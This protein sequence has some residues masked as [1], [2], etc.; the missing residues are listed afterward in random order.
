MSL[1]VNANENQTAM[2]CSA[3]SEISPGEAKLADDDIS[4]ALNW[5]RSI[6]AC[7]D[8]L[9]NFGS[10]AKFEFQ[11]GQAYIK[12]GQDDKGILRLVKAG[13]QGYVPAQN[14]LATA[15]YFGEGVSQSYKEALK[16]NLK[17]AKQGDY[18]SQFNVGYAYHVGEGVERDYVVAA[19]W[20]SMSAEQGYADAQFN[21]AQSYFYGEGVEQNYAQ[22]SRLYQKAAE[23]GDANAMTALGNAL[24]EGKGVNQDV[25]DGIMWLTKAANTGDIDAEIALFQRY[26]SDKNISDFA[27]SMAAEHIFSALKNSQDTMLNY[28]QK[29]RVK[30]LNYVMLDRGFGVNRNQKEAMKWLKDSAEDGFFLAQLDLAHRLA[31]GNGV[32]ENTKKAKELFSII[33]S[34]GH[35]VPM[36]FGVN[37]T[38]SSP[39]KLS[40]QCSELWSDNSSLA[41]SP[42][43]DSHIPI[44]LS[45]H[46][47]LIDLN[48]IDTKNQTVNASLKL[49]Y[50]F[51]DVR[52]LF[53]KAYFGTDICSAP[54]HVLWE[55]LP[56]KEPIS[57]SPKIGALNANNIINK[58]TD[59]IHLKSSGSVAYES[60][61]LGDF[62][63][64]LNLKNFPLDV[65]SVPLKF[66]SSTFSLSKVRLIPFENNKF[67]SALNRNED[68]QEWRIVDQKLSFS[69]E[70]RDGRLFSIATFNIDIKRSPQY[71]IYKVI[72][73][74]F[75]LFLVA[76]SQFWLRWDRLDARVSIATTSLVAVIAYQFLIQGDLPKLPYLTLLDKIVFLTF[77][78]IALSIAELVLVFS[79]IRQKRPNFDLSRLSPHLSL[80]ISPKVLAEKIDTHS[81]YAF[82]LFWLISSGILAFSPILSWINA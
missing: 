25:A 80:Q 53:N 24:L 74:L 30:Y 61:I 46:A 6:N 73:P 17:S 62:R 55:S 68:R 19:K 22:A 54:A 14:F 33:R 78:M 63:T 72:L 64:K 32:P 34:S 50:S 48:S 44:D 5:E 51:G 10:I 59:L 60:E 23:Q 81:R 76:T 75:I 3:L 27:P 77:I 67:N 2:P 41:R 82:P 69:N 37:N 12:A 21:L 35:E 47:H 42:D 31:L 13:D 26:I 70:I 11:L 29:P 66:G 45:L 9:R 65:Q 18:H 39:E 16:W 38:D 52:Y 28:N 15:F 8:A 57:W 4:R 36:F 1:N 71:Y 40:K 58:Q 79:L 43:Q 56:G 7:E 49:K 20:Y